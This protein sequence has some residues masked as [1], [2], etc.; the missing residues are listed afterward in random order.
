MKAEHY[1]HEEFLHRNHSINCNWPSFI[2]SIIDKAE[3]K[4]KRRLFAK[5]LVQNSE[6]LNTESSIEDNPL[7][8]INKNLKHLI[9]VV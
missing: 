7:I 1:F 4:C 2:N 9:R 3:L 5:V 6:T 8:F